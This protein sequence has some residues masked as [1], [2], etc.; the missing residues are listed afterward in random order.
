MNYYDYLVKRIGEV[1]SDHNYTFVIYPFGN[2]GALTKG[3]LNGI[4]AVQEKMIIDNVLCHQIDHI[5]GLDDINHEELVGCKILI[6]SDN[7]CYYEELRERLYTVIDKEQCIE[8]FPVPDAIK[9]YYR[10]KAQISEKM[11]EEGILEEMPIYHPKMTNSVFYLP[12]LLKDYIQKS[13]FLTDDYYERTTLDKVF[14]YKNGVVKEKVAYGTILDIGANIGNHTLYFCNECD[15]KKVYCFEPVG[16][17]YSILKENIRL[18]HLEQS[19]SM[20]PI[21]LG[22]IE[23]KAEPAG[24]I[25]FNIGGTHLEQSIDGS[26]CIK[27]LDDLNFEGKIVFIKIDV[28]GMEDSVLKG[29]ANLIK[30]NLPFIMVESFES[31]F[32]QVK[33]FLCGI[34]YTYESLDLSGNWLFYPN[35]YG[36]VKK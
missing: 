2:L 11:A 31:K 18:N 9:E 36:T 22:E 13:I 5:K 28:E 24:Y 6:A 12:L 27:R 4:Y 34:G 15:A 17:T 29:G 1:V 25:A 10:T 16:A 23:G 30:K 33:E 21:G 32:A 7:I 20:L 14:T 19:V 26:I 3:I 35:E 8:L